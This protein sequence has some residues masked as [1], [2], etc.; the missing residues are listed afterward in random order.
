MSYTNLLFE[1]KDEIAYITINRPDK[2]N[3]LNNQTMDELR[4]AFA[5]IHDDHSV[6]GVIL[7]GAGEK[8][9]VAGADIDELSRL[10]P[11]EARDLS[12]ANNKFISEIEHFPKPVIAA[13]NGFCLGGG[14]ELA[15]ACHLRWASENAKFGQPEVNLGIICGYGGTQRLSRLVGKGRAIE[16]VISGNMID[17]QEAHRI[18]L[19]NHVVPQDELIASCEKYLKTVFQKGPVAVKLSLEAVNRGLEMSLE[20]GIAYEANLFGLAFSTEDMQ[21]GTKAFL[22]K[23]EAEFR[24]K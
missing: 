7:T 5:T 8:A 16:L 15:I 22:E 3:A 14:N 23:R 11:V 18:G 13:V 2:L 21:E 9:F 12:L 24:G 1:Q 6:K 10:N 17:A 4:R 19:V 20:D